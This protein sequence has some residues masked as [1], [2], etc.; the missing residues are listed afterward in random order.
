M[1]MFENGGGAVATLSWS[2]ASQPKQ[3]IPSARAQHGAA[4]RVPAHIN[5]QLAG[6]P[7]P[8]RLHRRTPASSFGF[9]R[10]RSTFGW[11]V[12]HTDVTRDRNINADQRLDTLCHFHAGGLWEVAVPNGSYSVLVSIGD[13]ALRST[14]TLIVEG[15]TSFNAVA[16]N[17]NQ[18]QSARA[19]SRWRTAGSPSRRAARSTRRRASTTSKSRAFSSLP[20]RTQAR[21][22]LAFPTGRR[23]ALASIDNLGG[24]GSARD[25]NRDLPLVPFI[26]FLLCLIAFLLVTAVWS[27]E[28]QIDMNAQVPGPPV[29]PPP[30]Q[31][32]L[33]HVE[34][35]DNSFEL[36]WRQGATVINVNRVDRR[37]VRVGDDVRYPELA[38]RIA[39]EWQRFGEHR[40]GADPRSGSSRRAHEQRHRIRR[41]RRGARR[42]SLPLERAGPGQRATPVP[43]F[44]VSFAAN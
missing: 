11:N 21:T 16:L 43:A 41:R 31:P 40:S 4:V 17:P 23:C 27:Q 5:F 28:S 29:G 18:F 30:E 42:N 32:K 12:T 19:R 13:A 14:H 37:P 33:L 24:H 6:A 10:R 35:R 9:A 20:S 36:V 38:R 26:D 44:S 22:P 7:I 1:E 39:E 2:S 8:A 34:V 25:L 15:V 3:I